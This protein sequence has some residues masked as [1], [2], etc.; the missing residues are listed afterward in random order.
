MTESSNS[1]RSEYLVEPEWLEAHL[2][3]P[4]LAIVDM[5]SDAGYERGHLPGAVPL[6]PDYE[7]H[8][9]T[10]WVSTMPPDKFA[11]VCR[12]LGIGDHSQVVVYDNNMGLAAARLWWVLKLYGH[13]NVRVLNGGWRAWL[14]QNRP[15]SFDRP[16]INTTTP[17]TPRLDDSMLG[18]LDDVKAACNLG[19]AVIWDTRTEG[20]YDGSV[21][22]GNARAGHIA[23]AVHL[24]WSELV[25][26]ATH[27]FKSDNE[28]RAILAASGITPDKTAYAY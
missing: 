4:D 6:H 9:D 27:R 8:P 13:A 12:G 2:G 20:E 10:G 5:D 23:G 22:R 11:E 24:E 15:I 26:S 1:V 17:F 16:V 18:L 14:Q 19:D 3:D 7:R 28:M 25:D 21:N